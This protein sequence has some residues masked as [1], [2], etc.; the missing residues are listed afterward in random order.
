[1]QFVDDAEEVGRQWRWKVIIIY[2]IKK[3]MKEVS[4]NVLKLFS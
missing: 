1:V 4:G 3:L 2:E